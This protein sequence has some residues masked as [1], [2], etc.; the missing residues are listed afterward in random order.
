[1]LP[2]GKFL[3]S[4]KYAWQG[5]LSF[6]QSEQNTRVHLFFSVL[7]VILAFYFRV[8]R[9]EW[10]ALLICIAMVWSAEIFNTAI[11]KL[12]DVVSPEYHEKI[13]MVKDLA[14]AAVLVCAIL[15]VI[16]GT[17]IFGNKLLEQHI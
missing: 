4:F 2:I 7:V 17:I 15:S 9:S 3:L 6:L 5:F 8:G 1:M 16:I 11:E 14:A 13:K 10:L 12:A